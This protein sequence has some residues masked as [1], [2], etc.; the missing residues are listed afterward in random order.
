MFYSCQS[1]H[2]LYVGTSLYSDRGVVGVRLDEDAETDLDCSLNAEPAV[3]TR[4]LVR[5]AVPAGT[6]TLTIRLKSEGCFYF[7]FLEAAVPSDIPDAL[8]AIENVSPALDYSTDHTY[9]L[10]PARILWMF[11]Q[12][13]YAGP[14]NEYIG[15]FWWN[16]RTRVDALIP[17]VAVTF[18]GEF[19]AGDQVFVS[20]GGQTCGKTVFPNEDA[21]LIARHFQHFINA[22]YVGVWAAAEGNVLSVT[23][24]SPRPAYSFTFQ[25]WKETTQGS[26]GTVTSVGSL[27]NGQAG[28]WMVDPLQT[29]ALNRGARDWHLDLFNECGLRGR[30]VT[31]AASMELVNPPADFGARYPDGQVVETV[32]R[33]RLSGFNALRVFEPDAEL[34]E[35]A[36]QGPG[37]PHGRGFSRPESPVRR[38]LL[39]VF[40]QTKPK[41]P[42]GGMAYY[43]DETKAAAETALGRPLY[44]FTLPRGRPRRQWRRRCRFPP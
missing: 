27:E 21:A 17:S 12:L 40:C 44:T 18:D 13:G 15:V 31:V 3:V 28:R 25:A 41:S 33:L 1:P 20:I 8:P 7:D 24:R 4:R 37:G 35:A 9:K 10:P 11:D 43:D 29:P 38:V 42:G 19:L 36:L 14:M 26:S 30:E 2:D 16:Q 22:T 6:H 39:V 23:A 34:P 5:S 32:S